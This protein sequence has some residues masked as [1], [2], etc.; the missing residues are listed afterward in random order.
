M[1]IVF[2]SEAEFLALFSQY[3]NKIAG[4]VVDKFTNVINPN[5]RPM[6]EG[7]KFRVVDSAKM[8]NWDASLYST[9]LNALANKLA[10]MANVIGSPSSIIPLLES[11]AR[12][13]V[14]KLTKPK[15]EQDDAGT[16][17]GY[18]HFRWDGGAYTL[19]EF[20]FQFVRD[21]LDGKL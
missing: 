16:F 21:Y 8:D 10:Y 15:R 9:G 6:S 5:H 20:E 4:A 17:L 19:V 2:N 7:S 13:N 14:K 18:G 11:I 3:K 12:N 1:K